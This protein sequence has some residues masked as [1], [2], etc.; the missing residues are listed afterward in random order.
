MKQ[1]SERHDK[2]SEIL[3]FQDYMEQLQEHPKRHLRTSY[4]YLLDMIQSF[5]DDEDGLSKLFTQDHKD[6]PAVYGHHKVQQ[7]LIKNLVNFKEEGF[8]NKFILL[9]GPNGSSKSSLVKKLIKGLELY[10]RQEEGYLYT[11][12]WVFP[13]DP[14]LKGSL[15]L[16]NNEAS[17]EVN[18]FAYLEDKDISAIINSELKDH[19]VLLIPKDYRQNVINELL[20]GD[21]EYL[22]ETQKNYLYN[23]DL[24]KRNNMIY[25]ALLKSYKGSHEDVLKH[26]RVE[27]FNIS[28]RYSTGAVTIE[29]QMHVDAQMQQI[30]MDKRLASL[31][32]SLQSLNL[33]STKGQ[34]VLANRGILEYSDLLKRPLDTYKYLLTT[35]ETQNINLQGIL[36]ELDI[37]FVGTSNEVHLAAFKQHPDFN[38]FKGRINFIRVPY[39]LNYEKEE[40]IYSNQLMGL[41][42]KCHFEPHAL[43]A[44]CLF[45][46]LSRIRGP[47][48]KNYQDKNLANIATN[49]NPMEKV[50]F[51]TT[52]K[53]P[54]RLNSE[55]K[56]LLET[57]KQTVLDEFTHENLYEGKFGI[58]PRSLKSII[59]DIS[60]KR[61]H[62]TFI[63]VIDYL[64]HFITLKNDH[65]FL[66]MTPQADYHHPARFLSY[67]K[68][69]CFDFLDKELRQSLGMVDERSYEDHI[70]HYV[71]NVTALIKGE[72]VKN[73]IT[74]KYEAV[75]IY[76]VEEFEKSINLKEKA[77]DFRSNLLSKIGAYSLDHPGEDISYVDVLPELSNLLRESFR[78]E[79]KKVIQ[80]ISRN[81]VFFESEISNKK[82]S[83]NTPMSREN[84]EQIEQVVSKLCTKFHYSK[85]GAI[86]LI[87]VLIKERY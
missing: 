26:I 13:I 49:L 9:V 47:Q 4:R 69:H 21:Q 28:K 8:N 62:I 75:D 27:K 19:P 12:S 34:V 1:A 78:S 25:D 76:R 85:N 73:L 43:T 74:A 54:E 10:S 5:G 39:L 30:T 37:F 77:E 56:Q 6:A 63:D 31:P 17:R 83:I 53:A 22:Q 36:T 82:D 29:P 44:L 38:S 23:G 79:Q 50:L 67:I 70:K 66:N 57:S 7:E 84:R 72:K 45:A 60:N 87:K 11:F 86:S 80:I 59:Y 42:E 20:G 58:S 41:K 46:V 51:I 40:S 35:M 71:A 55:E 65:D 15:G 68:G 61:E 48:T 81:L 32:P 64:E 2:Q 24:S 52:G 3:S 18:S 16:A 33:F 14:Y